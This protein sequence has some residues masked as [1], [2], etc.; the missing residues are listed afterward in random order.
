MAGSVTTTG[1]LMTSPASDFTV[2][3][4]GVS[5]SGIQ[6]ATVRTEYVPV[7]K[8]SLAF[9]LKFDSATAVMMKIYYYNTSKTFKSIVL[10][11]SLSFTG[12]FKRCEYSG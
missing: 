9:S 4:D 1:A 5:F 7:R 11:T 2:Y 10:N 12:I 6:G 8:G 3:E